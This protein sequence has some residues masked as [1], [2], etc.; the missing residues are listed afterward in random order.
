[1][2]NFFQLNYFINKLLKYISSNMKE[3]SKLLFFSYCMHGKTKSSDLNS[4]LCILHQEFNPGAKGLNFDFYMTS[5][6]GL[7][8]FHGK[9]MSSL[10]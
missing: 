2:K 6:I 10:M 3:N 1:M 4:G 7:F 8:H 9:Q 5:H